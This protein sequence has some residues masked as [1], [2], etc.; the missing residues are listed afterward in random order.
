MCKLSLLFFVFSPTLTG[1][2]LLPTVP[3]LTVAGIKHVE[4]INL[5]SCMTE[6]ERN[7]KPAATKQEI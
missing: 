4:E 2:K 6:R 7:Y 3:K 1:V 5:V